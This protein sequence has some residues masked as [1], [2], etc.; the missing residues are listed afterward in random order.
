MFL[1]HFYFTTKYIHD[2]VAVIT[3]ISRTFSSSQ[4]ETLD[5]AKQQSI[6]SHLPYNC[7][8]TFCLV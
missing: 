2:A 8:S 1:S 3:T 6:T 7:Q 5:F 4:T